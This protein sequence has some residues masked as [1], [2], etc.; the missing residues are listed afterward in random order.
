MV[1]PYLCRIQIPCSLCQAQVYG[2]HYRAVDIG[3]YREVSHGHGLRQFVPC[4]I[5]NTHFLFLSVSKMDRA[6]AVESLPHRKQGPAYDGSIVSNLEKNYHVL[7]M[8]MKFYCVNLI[9]FYLFRANQ[10]LQ[11]VYSIKAALSTCVPAF[12]GS[13]STQYGPGPPILM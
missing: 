7:I 6:Q 12:G 10:C 4:N 5:D 2:Q 13:Q 8:I 11:Q 9:S 3:S 1:K